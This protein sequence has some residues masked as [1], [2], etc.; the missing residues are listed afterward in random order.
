[1]AFRVEKPA[2]NLR[3]K[4]TELDFQTLPYQKVNPGGIIQQKYFYSETSGGAEPET[5][6]TNWQDT[7]YYTFYFTPKAVD[8]MI[9]IN[10]QG[11]SRIRKFGTT[12]HQMRTARY[13]GD[14]DHG[15]NEH[16]LGDGDTIWYF[17]AADS[18]SDP[19]WNQLGY[20]YSYFSFTDYDDDH[21]DITYR[22]VMQHRASSSTGTVR[23][24]ENS[25]QQQL[26]AII[27]EVKQ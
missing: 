23:I 19:D 10:W 16:P 25:G 3:S 26:N 27:T 8:S 11:R 2:F 14:D 22:Y 20:W 4:L 13:N 17:H 15:G 12:A 1:M 7:G 5:S 6:S 24:G 9:L 18:D 21:S